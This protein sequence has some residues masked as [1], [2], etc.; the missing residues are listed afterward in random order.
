MKNST[1]SPPSSFLEA[2]W[3]ALDFA[4]ACAVFVPGKTQRL[5]EALD[6]PLFAWTD[7]IKKLV[8]TV[9][10]TKYGNPIAA[11]V[12]N[13]R[14]PNET[15]IKSIVHLGYLKKYGNFVNMLIDKPCFFR[16]TAP[17]IL[18]LNEV[19]LPTALFNGAEDPLADTADVDWLA[20]QL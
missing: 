5:I 9:G 13:N 7:I 16:C 19:T 1:G 20:N 4:K 14:Y 12:A 3:A 8:A 18:P 15:S 11:K 10:D 6:S 2:G 17:E